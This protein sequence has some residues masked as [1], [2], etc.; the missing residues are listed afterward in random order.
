MR[1]RRLK[2]RANRV[3]LSRKLKPSPKRPL[4]M[5]LRQWPRQPP[6]K[7][8]R[9]LWWRCVVMTD[10]A[11]SAPSKRLRVA[12]VSLAIAAKGAAMDGPLTEAI[13]VAVQ[14]IVLATVPSVLTAAPVWVMRHSVPIAM[15]WNTPK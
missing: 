9:D 14:V 6:S 10:L 8:P 3:R 15:P 13:A 12:A 1:L 11:K 7:P 4:K 5:R 2:Q